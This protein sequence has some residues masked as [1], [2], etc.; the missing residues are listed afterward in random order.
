VIVKPDGLKRGL[1]GEILARFE[2]SGLK[3]VGIKMIHPGE[4][5]VEKHYPYSREEFIKGMGEKTLKVY[6]EYGKDP[7][8]TFGTK[9]PMEIGKKI[10]S[11]NIAFLTSN[12]VIV[13]LLEGAHAVDNARAVA[14]ATMPVAAPGGTIRGDFALDSAA[15][16][17]E[18]QRA[19]KNLIHVSG[20]PEEA[21]YEE[22][23]WFSDNEKFDYKRYGEE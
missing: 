9:D 2:R 8:E 3:I 10:N 1:T 13:V 11:W 18:E 5:L 4:D 17:N 16:A 7:V 19:V 14:G 6:E 21:K 23:I 12:P 15:Y 20:S 22:D